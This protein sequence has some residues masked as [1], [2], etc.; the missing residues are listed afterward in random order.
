M[1]APLNSNCFYHIFSDKHIPLMEFVAHI[2]NS[3]ELQTLYES[4][5]SDTSAGSANDVPMNIE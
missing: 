1:A 5:Q 3:Q 4:V 2:R